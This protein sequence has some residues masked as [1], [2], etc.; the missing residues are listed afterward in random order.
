MGLNNITFNLGKGGLG[1]PLPG[2]D[3][4]SGLLFYT[5]N[6]NLPSGFTT[7]NRILQFFSVTDAETAGINSDYRDATPATGTYLVTAIGANGDTINISVK[8]LFGVV[9]NLG[10]YTKTATETTA[11]LVGAAI[12]AAINAGTATHGF[13]ATA[14]TGTVTITAPKSFGIFLNSGTP[15]V[16][17]IVGTIAGTLTQF[18]GGVSSLQAIWHYHIAEYFRIQPQGN[19]Y[20]GFFAIPGTYNFNEVTT[21]QTFAIG[22]IRQIGIYKDGTALAANGADL[23]AID[24]VCKANVVLHKELIGLLGA[25]ISGTA[26][27]STLY[28]MSQLSANTAALVISQD[29]AALGATLFLTYGKSITNL[30]ALLG[31]VSLAAVDESIAWVSKFN[32]SNGTECDTIAF[33]NGVLDSDPSITD[34]LRGTLQGYRYIFLRKFTG[35]AGS[36]FNEEC[37]A[38]IPTSDYAFISRNRT[39]QKATRGIYVSLLDS[40]NGPLLL[41]ADGTLAQTTIDFLTTEAEINLI[42]MIRDGELSAEKVTIDPTQN[43]LSTGTLTLAVILVPVG[44]ARQIVVNIGYKLSL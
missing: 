7:T 6:G 23:T 33:A 32:I 12:A 20:V 40:L 43:V 4:I 8:G 18:S 22:K 5:A 24:V 2:Q 11:T 3:F 30:G 16:V 14:L 34:S 9:W 38:V 44:V 36:F 39:I 37:M 42:Q 15:I 27:V 19:L 21:M 31:A 35:K 17:T 1:A 28:D 25:D 26:N 13:T 10:T 41:N 29:G